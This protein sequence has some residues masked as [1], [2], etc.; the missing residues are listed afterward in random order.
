MCRAY[1]CHNP[2]THYTYSRIQVFVK[3]LMMNLFQTIWSWLL[4]PLSGDS[5][6]EITHAVSWHARLM[7]L[8]WGLLLPLGVMVARFLKI[9]PKQDWPRQL[10]NKT[11]WRIHLTTQKLGVLIACVGGYLVAGEH[12]TSKHPSLSQLH[13][14]AGWVIVVMG[15]LQAIGGILRGSKGGPTEACL[16]GDHY[17]M[18]RRRR[19]FETAHKVMGYGALLLAVCTILLGLIITDAPRWMVCVLS[20]WWLCLI[21]SFMCLQNNGWCV[22]TYQAIWGD[23]LEH[24]GNQ[25]PPAG[26]GSH[27]HTQA[28]FLARFR[29]VHK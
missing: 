3:V 25:L 17:D 29:R 7:V 4:T 2:N 22:D 9:M 19:L 20:V 6:H 18:S 27:R 16:R 26:W 15:L 13:D 10:D 28:S 14:Y 5:V 21:V 12:V 23:S 24:P 1:G 11:W 8:S